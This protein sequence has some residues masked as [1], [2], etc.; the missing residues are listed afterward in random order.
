MLENRPSNPHCELVCH[1]LGKGAV[2][3]ESPWNWPKFNLIGHKPACA[4]RTIVIIATEYRV[5]RHV[6]LLEPYKES[7]VILLI[8]VTRTTLRVQQNRHPDDLEG[9]VVP[10]S[11]I[12]NCYPAHVT[13][14]MYAVSQ[15]KDTRL[16]GAS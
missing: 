13:S 4:S 7:Y 2:V 14:R 8:G 5:L 6:H 16:G 1:Q 3:H 12:L 15:H 9:Y 10:S 11:M